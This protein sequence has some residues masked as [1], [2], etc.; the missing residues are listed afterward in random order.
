MCI[1]IVVGLMQ[2]DLEEFVGALLSV[3]HVLKSARTREVVVCG[4]SRSHAVT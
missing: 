2:K 3:L 4:L 1:P